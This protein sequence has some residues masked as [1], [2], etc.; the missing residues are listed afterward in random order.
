ML[1]FLVLTSLS[2][3]AQTLPEFDRILLPVVT[4]RPVAGAHDSK[5]ETLVTIRN[6]SDQSAGELHDAQK[7]RIEIEPQTTGIRYWAFVS[8]TNNE[9]QQIT[10]LSVH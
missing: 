8:V 4:R 3:V 7:V 10:T 9:T 5:W 2:A 1:T 6:G